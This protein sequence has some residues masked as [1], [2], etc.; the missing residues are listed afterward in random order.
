MRAVVQRVA[1]AQ[2]N[3]DGRTVGRC[4]PGLLVLVAAH[5]WDEPDQA[6]KM[7]DRLWGLR[8]F[9][10]AEGRINVAL[11]DLPDTGAPKV[12]AVSNFTV[13]GDTAKNRRPSF[14][15]SAPFDRG[16]ELVDQMVEELRRL[17]CPVETG[18]FGAHMEVE[19]V[20]DGPVTVIV[21]VPPLPRTP[22][23]H[24]VETATGER[25]QT[26]G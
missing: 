15:E 11:K 24:E 14:T 2:V 26:D 12:L 18:E 17:G 7:A 5:R 22:N 13:Y 10:D 25:R 4:G 23:G 19:A 1:R 20:C 16:R 21:D 3:V 9:N 6:R 8:I